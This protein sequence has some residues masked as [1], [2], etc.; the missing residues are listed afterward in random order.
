MGEEDGG[1][2]KGGGGGGG[3]EVGGGEVDEA[4][5]GHAF[6]GA[7]DGDAFGGG[8]APEEGVFFFGKGKVRVGA[9]VV[10]VVRGGRRV[11]FY[12]VHVVPR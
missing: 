12:F 1:L 7:E 10:G 3:G 2:G 9:L 6:P 11:V 4:L 8:A 5:A